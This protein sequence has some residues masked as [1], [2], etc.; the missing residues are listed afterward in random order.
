M[1]QPSHSL[2]RAAISVLVLALGGCGGG[3][4]GGNEPGQP[5]NVAPTAAAGADQ[6]AIEGNLVEL[7][8][9]GSTDTDGSISTFA[10]T[11]TAGPAVTLS[12]ASSADPTFTAP[13][14]TSA[15]AVT[16]QLTVTD[17]E[18]G[19]DTDTVR[20]A[21]ADDAP[22]TPVAGD[23][24]TVTEEGIISFDGRASSD[25]VGI[26]AISW[27][28]LTGTVNATEI[29]GAN[30][31]QAQFRAP[32]VS[33]RTQIE[34]ELEVSDRQGQT[35]DDNIVVTVEPNPPDID[36]FL[37][38]LN[39]DSPKYVETEETGTAYYEAIDP[40]G[41]KTTLAAWKTVNGFDNGFAA[42]AVYRNAAD[43]GFGRAMFMRTNANGVA[44]YVENYP[45]LADAVAAVKAGNNN[46]IIATVAMEWSAHP[47]GGQRYVKF[48]TFRA[49]GTRVNLD[50]TV[51]APDLDGRG[52]KFQPGVCN[53]CHGGQPKP[54][55]GGAYPDKGNTD[56]QFLPWDV[57]S[58]E[59]SDDPEFTRAAQE[60]QFKKLNEGALST[61]PAVPAPG[62]WDSK[63]ARDLVQGWYG[64]PGMPDAIFN[65][66]FTPPDWETT[67]EIKDLYHKVVARNCRACHVQRGTKLT[68]GNVIA[69]GS[70]A[71]FDIYRERIK[72]LVFDR[73]TMPDA[74]LTF[75]NFWR[76]FQNDEPAALLATHLGIDH[77]TRRPGRPVADPGPNRI[78]G[79]DSSIAQL[80]GSASLFAS[81][82]KWS[83]RN[84]LANKPIGS[85][86]TIF[87]DTSPNASLFVD[88]IGVY[89]LQLVVSDGV[90]ESPPAPIDILA[91]NG[92]VTPTFNDVGPG[93][94]ANIITAECGASCHRAVGGTLGI[95]V[96][97]DN[98]ATLYNEVRKYVNL[99]QPA[100][101]PIL[102]KPSGMVPHGGNTPTS[103][104]P[105]TGFESQTQL[106]K[107][108]AVLRWIIAGAQNN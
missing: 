73:G 104:T 99:E 49:D 25:D 38:F 91:F 34:F 30:T 16:L 43:L 103:T 66:G 1:N 27:S 88:M 3:G 35:V 63:A 21:V 4:G 18:G 57:D 7:N 44:A 69:F 95:P 70:Y 108:D 6:S 101:S 85:A 52:E 24:F 64:G 90:N 62:E 37:T 9:S 51:F 5:S 86:T 58:F 19:T 78:V 102:M 50:G 107:Y 79:L 17:N 48:Y 71:D 39:K 97:F 46:R 12:N 98:L 23:D 55:V 36:R 76:G 33:Q 2:F 92:V 28:Q 8:G 93:G 31:L 45:T 32:E 96:R 11:Q 47:S 20:I 72:T 67:Q 81:T 94:I 56:A 40:N 26:I 89:K 65:G 10:W 75:D 42:R 80:N 106:N 22:P 15:Q 77:T 54:L 68:H 29:S 74:R 41:Q 61:Y 82:Y 100:A 84:E 60:A 83:F 105:R 13:T 53:V 14:I 87:S 59:F